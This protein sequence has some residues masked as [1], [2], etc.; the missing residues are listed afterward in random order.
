[1]WTKK[2]R[3]EAVLNGELADRPPVSAWRHFLETEHSGAEDFANSMLAFQKTYDWDYVK[4]QN[5]ATYYEEVWGGE[6]DYEDYR[7]GV[8]APCT[9]A[10][11]TCA[12]DLEKIVE[13]PASVAPL[14]EQVEAARLIVEGLGDDTPVFP[15][16][17][18]PAAVFQKMCAVDSIGRYRPATRED[19]MVTLMKEHPEQVH[20]ALRNITRTLAGYARELVK[21]GIYGVFYAAT[22]LS[23][24]GY[25]TRSEWEEF[26]RPYDMELIEALKPCKIMV[27]D[28]GIYC[29]P[30]WFADYPID[31][32]HWP[33]SA[34]GNP[35]LD[36]A[37]GWLGRITPMGGV[38]ERPF[39]Q[40]QAAHIG[41]LTRAT[42]KKM[43]Q[44]P[45]ML[46]PDCSISVHTTHEELM[47]F[48]RAS[49]ESVS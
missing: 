42:L 44:I 35:A 27:H 29:N 11:I 13:K 9:K 7:G 45:F 38:D 48:Y 47:A 12:A 8:V 21:T 18:C 16:I 46:A 39:G 3:V 34:T 17:F 37:P 36:S 49:H 1:M 40:D 15:S 22:G 28:C 2:E 10:P 26:V 33:E 31:I 25:L 20:T 32:L 43:K 24:T 41:E 5:R 14:A 19:L 4:A 30:E 23:R 6:F